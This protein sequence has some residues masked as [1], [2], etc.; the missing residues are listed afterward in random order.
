M[1]HTMLAICV[2]LLSACTTEDCDV[3]AQRYFGKAIAYAYKEKEMSEAQRTQYM[4]DA[5]VLVAASQRID[6]GYRFT[7]ADARE[8]EAISERIMRLTHDE[9]KP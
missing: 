4:A 2:A 3:K 6:A 9:V 5:F 8:F 1:K 7:C